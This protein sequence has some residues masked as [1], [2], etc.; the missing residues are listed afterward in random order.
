[1][2]IETVAIERLQPAPY[3]PRVELKPGMAEF[4]RLKR[5]LTEFDLVQPLVWNERTGH[6]VGGH[7]RLA[8]LQAEGERDVPV[9]VVD[10]PM[11]REKALN[12]VL[13]NERA[14]GRWD[15][16]KLQD[17]MGELVELPDFDETLTGFSEEDL[18]DLMLKPVM[19]LP[20][21]SGGDDGEVVVTCHVHQ[22]DWEVFR[23][24]MDE[25]LDE[26]EFEM[27]VKGV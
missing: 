16:A 24:R 13:N 27:H 18:N 8:I 23:E 15:V 9:V 12:V 22:E 26:V 5:S 4:E 3:N 14:G 10:L 19:E 7:Q 21:E 6:V 2:R 25:L 20:V 1:M 11:E 17:L